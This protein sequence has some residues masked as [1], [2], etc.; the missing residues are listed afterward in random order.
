M[1]DRP[2]CETCRWWDKEGRPWEK[3]GD[4]DP[5]RCRRHPPTF[6]GFPSAYNR[7]WCGEHS[8]KDTNK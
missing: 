5:G 3:R 1:T 4:Y 7:D 2:T 8:A 6:H